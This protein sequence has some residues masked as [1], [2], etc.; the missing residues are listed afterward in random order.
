ML[1]DELSF[2]SKELINDSNKIQINKKLIGLIALISFII[3]VLIIILILVLSPSKSDNISQIGYINCNYD[4]KIKNKE[5]DI[6]G[7]KF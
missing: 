4:I 3:V 7:E 2:S 1:E 5:I 6:L